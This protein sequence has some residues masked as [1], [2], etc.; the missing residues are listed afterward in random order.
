MY[1]R[2]ICN[3][4]KNIDLLH[5]IY[6][7]INFFL[8]FHRPHIRLKIGI[9]HL[10]VSGMVFHGRCCTSCCFY[11]FCYFLRLFVGWYLFFAF[12]LCLLRVVWG[13]NNPFWPAYFA[14]NWS[15]N[16]INIVI[17]LLHYIIACIV[18][19]F[20]KLHYSR[21]FYVIISLLFFSIG[22]IIL[23]LFLFLI[24]Y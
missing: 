22:F 10:S 15:L 16:F 11:F 20:T 19:Y 5:W 9:S 4:V 17:V 14:F 18:Y 8:S 7:K 6:K 13:T 21:L 24:S 23:F 2:C 1:C 12:V 3:C